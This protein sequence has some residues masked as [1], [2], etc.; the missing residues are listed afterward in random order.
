MACSPKNVAVLGSTGSIG[1]N[2]LRVIAESG[3]ALRAKAIS[4]HTQLEK[5]ID[6]AI[7]LEPDYVIATCP[8]E[9]E[10]QNWER[11]PSGCQLRVGQDETAKV[12]RQQR[13]AGDGRAIGDRV[14]NKDG[15]ND[16]AD[17]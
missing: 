16:F 4:A 10:K 15:S 11:L 6:Q 9:A 12:V 5:L 7:W 3:G 8:E 14:G 2:T 17:R 13:N 1:S